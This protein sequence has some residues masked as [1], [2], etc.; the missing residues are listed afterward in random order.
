M[1]IFIESSQR[2]RRGKSPQT[3]AMV[4]AISRI[5]EEIQPC[6]VRAVCYQL[7]VRK[8]ISGMTKNNTNSVGGKLVWARENGVIPW[9]WIVDE[10]REA[11]TISTWANPESIINA[12]VR[13]YRKDYWRDQPNWVEV[14]SEKGT[15]RGTLAPVLEK[16]GITFRV[17][18]GYSSAT[19]LQAIATESAA[20]DKTLHVL[21]LGD[22][23]P[24][25]MNM[26]EVD[27]PKRLA[28]YH[29]DVIVERIALAD[30]DVAPG[31]QLPSFEASTKVGDSRYEWF[32]KNYGATCW[33]L[34][35]LSPTV[36]RQRV[37]AR[38]LQLI[39]TGAWNA[40]I[41]VEKAEVD[42]MHDFMA[43]WKARRISGLASKYS[44][45]GKGA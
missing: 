8:L 38:I 33:E 16:Y 37:D 14:W 2:R 32:L 34:D 3:L 11:E 45:S 40:A 41:D 20:S 19:A 44:L 39:D 18:H 35:A 26:S 36:L 5:L 21:Y 27:I 31:T 4:D 23:D 1:S 24:S 17:M 12:A 9:A 22:W 10:T 15:I 25:G 6:S 43:A 30:S 42:S 13:G 29:G 28:R 7:F